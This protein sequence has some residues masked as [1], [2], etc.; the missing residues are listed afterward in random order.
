MGVEKLLNAL[1]DLENNVV[2]ENEENEGGGRGKGMEWRK[3]I[4]VK[5]VPVRLERS[6]R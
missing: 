6:G 2:G 5:I 1:L 3:R 4:T